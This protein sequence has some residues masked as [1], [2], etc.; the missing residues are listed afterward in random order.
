MFRTKIAGVL[1]NHEEKRGHNFIFNT[2]YTLRK[3]QAAKAKLLAGETAKYNIVGLGDSMLVGVGGTTE[4]D[5]GF[6]GVLRD[7]L[8]TIYG[9]T[10]KGS[11][12]YVYPYDIGASKL[13]TYTGANWDKQIGNTSLTGDANGG[14]Y[15][16]NTSTDTITFDFNGTGVGVILAGAGSGFSLGSASI[17]IDGGAPTVVDCSLNANKAF[18]TE[19]TGLADD[20]HTCVITCTASASQYVIFN[21]HYPIKGSSGFVIHNCGVTGSNASQWN[22][23]N[24]IASSIDLFT[25]ILTMV[26]LGGNDWNGGL[27]TTAYKTNLEFIADEALAHGD[28]LFIGEG[29]FDSTKVPDVT[30]TATRSIFRDVMQQ[31][32]F[33]KGCAFVDVIKRH[34]GNEDDADTAQNNGLLSD[35]VHFNDYGHYDAFLAIKEILGI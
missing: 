4:R 34:N 28:C 26:G 23:L 6:V 12:N 27:T 5:N 30:P 25:P 16:N 20:D 18:A 33:E 2:A 8:H 14:Y 31:V 11:I 22:N 19:I 24:S 15:T 17:V 13:H 1:T 32:A 29:M 9:D 10:G 7:Y 21:G 35:D 3:F